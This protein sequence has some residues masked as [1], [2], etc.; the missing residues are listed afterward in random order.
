MEKELF[1]TMA[2]ENFD[3]DWRALHEGNVS[4]FAMT[5]YR[6]DN[7]VIRKDDICF[8]RKTLLLMSCPT[9]TLTAG[10]FG[11]KLVAVGTGIFES[12]KEDSI[13]VF[14]SRKKRRQAVMI[15][16]QTQN[17]YAY[18]NT[19]K[20]VP[21]DL[22]IVVYCASGNHALLC[23]VI[24]TVTPEVQ[25]ICITEVDEKSVATHFVQ[26][27][28]AF[29]KVNLAGA[30]TDAAQI[31]ALKRLAGKETSDHEE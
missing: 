15:V 7:G 30:T 29:L 26:L 25:S 6:A 21:K 1:N 27:S 20:G 23:T 16:N 28:A 5:P 12:F 18:F 17:V 13:A 3:T 4:L 31:D 2:C 11:R 9:G 24:Q 8:A 10:M 19:K 14:V 22:F